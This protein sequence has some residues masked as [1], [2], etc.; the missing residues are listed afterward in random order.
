MRTKRYAVTVLG[1]IVL[2]AACGGDNAPAPAPTEAPRPTPT[3]SPSPSPS[4]PSHR[5]HHRRR[6]PRQAQRSRP[7]SWGRSAI[8]S[9]PALL[10]TRRPPFAMLW[11]SRSPEQHAGGLHR[12]CLCVLQRR[13][14]D[15]RCQL[16]RDH[17]LRRDDQSPVA[18]HELAH[19]FGSGTTDE[20]GRLVSGGRFT[21]ARTT[22][23]IKAFDGPN[24]YL[25]AD[26]QHFWPLWPEL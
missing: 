16:P 20:W 7:T 13:H 23:R 3:P 5:H 22:A 25:N 4:P 6:H 17:P 12:Q 21:G 9:P 18:L 1:P 10:P 11:I 26:G 14:A 19:W 2:L 24:A 15:R 8:R